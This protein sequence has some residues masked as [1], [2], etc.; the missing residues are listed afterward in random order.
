MRRF[1]IPAA[2]LL[3]GAAGASESLPTGPI[4]R[5]LQLGSPGW[6]VT[7]VP[8]SALS[9]FY[10]PFVWYG[11]GNEWLQ[12]PAEGQ[13]ATLDETGT[14]VWTLREAPDGRWG[15][16][17][18]AGSIQ[19]YAF[20]VEIAST[21]T[22]HF[23]FETD[24]ALRA[25]VDAETAEPVI[26]AR[27]AVAGGRSAA[28][29]LAPGAHHVLLKHFAREPGQ[30]FRI[31]VAE[32]GDVD[33]VGLSRRFDDPRPP[34]AALEQPV[35]GPIHP[36]DHIV[37]AFSEPMAAVAA[38]FV[39][40]LTP[41]ADGTWEW[42]DH[43]RLCFR[44]GTPLSS[45]TAYVL[46]IDPA[47]ARDRAGNAL[48]GPTTFAFS[49]AALMTPSPTATDPGE[50]YP[51][52]GAAFTILGTGFAEGPVER[53]LG[54]RRFAE[55]YYRLHDRRSWVDAVAD[56]AALGG[57][58]ATPTS[59]SE[60]VFCWRLGGQVNAFI[61]LEDRDRDGIWAWVTGEPVAY[62]AWSPGEPN[63]FL[64]DG[65][66]VAIFWYDPGWNDVGSAPDGLRPSIQE[67]ERPMP[68][69][70]RLLGRGDGVSIAVSAVL[71]DG[72]LS[73]HGDLRGVP[74]GLYDVEVLN[75]GGAVG[76]L[77]AGLR[78]GNRVPT[79]QDLRLEGRFDAAIAGQVQGSDAD[80]DPL[81]YRI[82]APPSRGSASV[83]SDG[84]VAYTP[85]G[86]LGE[87]TFTVV[88]DDGV[89]ASSPATVTVVLQAGPAGTLTSLSATLEGRVPAGT[90]VI[91][92]D[93]QPIRPD[94]DGRWSATVPIATGARAV[95]VEYVDG[96]SRTHR[97]SL[98]VTRP[99]GG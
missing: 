36:V 13:T 77:A 87:V 41:P 63:D 27:A 6:A 12:Q 45:E 59:P 58:L 2:L 8:S 68:P 28:V 65:E 5:M 38:D 55:H 84:S 39:A 25:W 7:S 50:V 71:V 96:R 3:C 11:Y 30:G 10:D 46:S 42:S 26:D 18:P 76:V 49:T 91:R 15:S 24:T 85:A 74:R 97:R 47:M 95:E 78:I 34:T 52:E 89:A 9:I 81:T 64:G 44:P 31:R 60:N 1:S 62:A 16:D 51:V 73:C 79:V 56:A 19:Y 48:T 72:R 29:T 80:G 98:I 75:P 22:I 61:G 94:P 70:V 66:D 40:E 23:L 90:R 92:I 4:T 35:G 32:D 67:F 88:A 43:H 17:A 93:G 54:A 37:V 57:H 53:P 69:R 83:G 86:P 33:A 82:L 14:A 99:G 20:T 21:R